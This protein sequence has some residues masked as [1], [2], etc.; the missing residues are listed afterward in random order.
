MDLTKEQ[1]RN[2][3]EDEVIVDC[4]HEEEAN[5][6]WAIYMEDNMY[7]P[8]EAEYQVKK[9]NGEKHWKKVTVVNNETDESN[10]NGGDYYVEIEYEG[11]IIPVILD[12]LRNI[13]ADDETLRTIQIWKGRIMYG[14]G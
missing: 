4:Y 9:S 8:F 13:R 10:F 14:Y 12:N 2:I 7:Y 5:V 6:S 3:I 1:I 11:I